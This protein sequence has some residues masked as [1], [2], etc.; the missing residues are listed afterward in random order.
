MLARPWWIKRFGGT[1]AVSSVGMFGDG[2]GWGIPISPAPLMVT[3]GGI[4]PRLVMVDG[5]LEAREHLSL[6]ISVDHDIVDGAPAA[7]FA[8]RLRQLIENAHGLVAAHDP[9]GPPS[10]P[11]GTQGRNGRPGRGYPRPRAFG[12]LP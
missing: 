2:P 6:T 8:A 11:E 12:H 3:V 5:H 4:G 9:G 1:I 10:P 7:R